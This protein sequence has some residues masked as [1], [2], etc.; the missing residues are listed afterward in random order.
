MGE[1]AS[2]ATALVAGNKLND[3]FN[4]GNIKN[5]KARVES[6][7]TN[8][9]PGLL[10]KKTAMSV[11]PARQRTLRFAAWLLTSDVTF[12]NSNKDPSKGNFRDWLRW[13]T[14]LKKERKTVH[15]RIRN[16]IEDN[17]ALDDPFPMVFRW[18]TADSEQ[19][20]KLELKIPT[21]F[22]AGEEHY[23]ITVTAKDG[24]SVDVRGDEDDTN[25]PVEDS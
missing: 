25:N 9:F 10:K 19:D 14:W 20:F 4:A 11:A 17:L 8:G 15:N 12:L 7:R 21:D 3:L 16:A 23:E 2:G 22:P 1:V 13:L 6:L 18:N 5:T 24:P